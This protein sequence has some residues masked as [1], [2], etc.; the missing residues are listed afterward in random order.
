VTPPLYAMRVLFSISFA[1]GV[2]CRELNT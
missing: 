2:W 1:K